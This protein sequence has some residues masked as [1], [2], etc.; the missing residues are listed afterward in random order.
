MQETDAAL[1]QRFC[2]AGDAEAFS[3]LVSRYSRLVYA[4]GH[5][6]LGERSRAEDVAQETFFQL[7]C[8]PRRVRGSVMGMNSSSPSPSA[9]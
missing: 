3:E 7:L 4:A 9:S 5:R 1:M 2:N 6:V 8:Q